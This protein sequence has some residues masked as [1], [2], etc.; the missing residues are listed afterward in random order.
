MITA[1][2]VAHGD[3]MAALC[4]ILLVLWVVLL[5]LGVLGLLVRRPFLLDP[6]GSLL[7]AV[8][9]LIVWVVLC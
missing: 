9:L 8:V 4:P 6:V 3:V 2:H 1:E 7:G 5:L